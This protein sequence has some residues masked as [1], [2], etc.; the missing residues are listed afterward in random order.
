MM[1]LA[2]L[3]IIA[4]VLHLMLSCS[5]SQKPEPPLATLKDLEK[6]RVQVSAL[7]PQSQV[8]SAKEVK[9]IEVFADTS[10]SP[11]KKIAWAQEQLSP[12]ERTIPR[13]QSLL[14]TQSQNEAGSKPS[15]TAQSSSIPGV[16]VGRG[17]KRKGAIKGLPLKTSARFHPRW[18]THNWSKNFITQMKP[19][20][21]RVRLEKMAEEQGVQWVI[22]RTQKFDTLQKVSRKHY[23]TDRRWT[24]IY[25]LNY[26]KIENWD[27]VLPEMELRLWP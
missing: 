16:Q 15:L 11:E 17:D 18:R 5:S 6:K 24:E 19:E 4:M 26:P 20:V 3:S 10:L 9:K 25:V 23:R 1:S 14:G 21:L 22:Y 27:K 8:A 12:D 7:P 13:P 2:S